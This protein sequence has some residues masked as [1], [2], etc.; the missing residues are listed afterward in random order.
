[1]KQTKARMKQLLVL[2]QRCGI[3]NKQGRREG[4]VFQVRKLA[5]GNE[6][7]EGQWKEEVQRQKN[8]NERRNWNYK[9]FPTVWNIYIQNTKSSQ[10]IQ[11]SW[12]ERERVDSLRY[13]EEENEVIQVKDGSRSD[14]G[15]TLAIITQPVIRSKQAFVCRDGLHNHGSEW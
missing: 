1:M 5:R 12:K 10:L 8:H 6:T 3:M 14:Q 4:N 15:N 9:N 11:E 2:S 7:Y 13:M